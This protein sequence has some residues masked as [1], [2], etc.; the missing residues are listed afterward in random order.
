MS[1]GIQISKS[2]SVAQQ[3][4]NIVGY[5]SSFLSF[6][7]VIVSI[8]SALTKANNTDIGSFNLMDV[9]YSLLVLSLTLT[10][11]DIIKTYLRFRRNKLVAIMKFFAT[12]SAALSIFVLLLIASI[13]LDFCAIVNGARICFNNNLSVVHERFGVGY[14][15]AINCLWV[16]LASAIL[17]GVA[18]I[19]KICVNRQTKN[20]ILQ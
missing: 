11:V 9:N 4:Y 8:L 6:S 3:S 5:D 7:I 1:G 18:G 12:I 13:R 14:F 2:N 15:K 17:Q 16:Y 20:N 10:S 19:L